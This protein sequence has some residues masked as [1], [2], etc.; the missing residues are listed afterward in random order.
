MDFQT[1]YKTAFEFAALKHEGQ[2]VPGTR[3]PY[4][5]HVTS[6][7]MEV[8]VAGYNTAGFDMDFAVTVAFLHDILEDTKTLYGELADKFGE[9]VAEGVLALTKF[10]SLEKSEQI[11]D[12]LNRIQ[13]LDKEV[14]SVKLADRITNLDAQPLDWKR[15]KRERYM[16]DSR[17]ILNKLGPAN[18]YLAKRLEVKVEEY[19]SYVIN[20]KK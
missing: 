13:D 9:R 18:A 16:N 7:A 3:L 14:W 10:Y 11:K 8:M 6:V 5:V 20:G 12:S 17:D 1:Y 4:L 2:K 19:V 15:E